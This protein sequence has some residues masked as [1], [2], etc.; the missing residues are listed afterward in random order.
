MRPAQRRSW[1][2]DGARHEASYDSASHVRHFRDLD[3]VRARYAGLLDDLAI[4]QIAIGCQSYIFL[5]LRPRRR[6]DLTCR[7]APANNRAGNL[8]ANRRCVLVVPAPG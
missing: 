7:A 5:D 1:R 6:P 8:V 3:E 2:R 4:E